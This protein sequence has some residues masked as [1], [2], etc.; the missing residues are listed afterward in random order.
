MHRL[1]DWLISFEFSFSF[2]WLPGNAM[3]TSVLGAVLFSILLYAV[4]MAN[5]HCCKKHFALIT[6]TGGPAPGPVFQGPQKRNKNDDN[7][8][9]IDSSGAA[10]IGGDTRIGDSQVFDA[11]DFPETPMQ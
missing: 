3:T 7:D 11:D 5:G 4:P 2:I 1:A 9:D 10:T 8:S 6:V